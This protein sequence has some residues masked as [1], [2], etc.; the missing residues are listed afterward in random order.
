MSELVRQIPDLVDVNFGAIK[1]ENKFLLSS[2][3]I[4]STGAA[5]VLIDMQERLL[6]AMHE[7]AALLQTILQFL[8]VCELFKLPIVYTEQYPQGLGPTNAEIQ[9]AIES[10]KNAGCPVLYYSKTRMSILNTTLQKWLVQHNI[11][12]LIVAGV[13]THVCVYQSCRDLAGESYAIFLP[14]DMVSSRK[15]AHKERALHLL[16]K[17]GVNV[18]A[19]E[20]IMFDLLQDAK[21]PHFKACQAL[22]K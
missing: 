1:V 3:Q 8:K 20:I 9:A 14:E 21:N 16:E 10:C 11:S 13:E 18:T 17:I 2:Q 5:F 22:I 7:N 12:Q 6:P 15:L 4:F 19:M